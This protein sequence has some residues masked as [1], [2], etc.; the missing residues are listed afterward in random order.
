M[1]K[2]FFI[3]YVNIFNAFFIANVN[4]FNTFFTAYVFIFNTF[5]IPYINIYSMFFTAYVPPLQIE[6]FLNI[7]FLNVLLRISLAR[8]CLCDEVYQVFSLINRGVR[9]RAGNL[10]F[11]V[12]N[13]G[14]DCPN[15]FSQLTCT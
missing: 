5:F 9:Y 2:Y 10:R 12:T 3:T 13:Y 7:F 4:T 6:V 11:C 1:F 8:R 14:T 15:N